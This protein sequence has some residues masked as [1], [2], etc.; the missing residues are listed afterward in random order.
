M[1]ELPARG[2]QYAKHLGNRPDAAL[3]AKAGPDAAGRN[4]GH[5]SRVDLR[6]AF[7]LID[8]TGGFRTAAQAP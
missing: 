1:F 5:Y 2:S 7:C 8:E 3:L 6:A 4:A